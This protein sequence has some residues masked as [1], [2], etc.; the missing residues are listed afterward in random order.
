MLVKRAKRQ[1]GRMEAPSGEISIVSTTSPNV[2]AQA[3][4]CS[5]PRLRRPSGSRN[6]CIVYNSTIVLEIGVPVANVTPCP[7]CRSCR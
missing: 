5:S 7:G 4:K 3:S 6:R 1:R 2:A